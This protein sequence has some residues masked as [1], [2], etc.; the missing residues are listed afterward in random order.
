[1][2]RRARRRPPVRHSLPPR[3]APPGTPSAASVALPEGGAGRSARLRTEAAFRRD[4][5]YVSRELRRIA[6][7]T[8]SC[9]G[10]LAILVVV[11]R[12]S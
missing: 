9:V 1:M 8:G 4:S 6:L 10:L 7:V 11:D 2:P 3:P 12:F 5:A